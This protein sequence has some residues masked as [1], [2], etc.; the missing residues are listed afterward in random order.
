MADSWLK[1]CWLTHA[2]TC[3]RSIQAQQKPEKRRVLA[4]QR[5][6][7][8]S[9]EELKS[10]AC[11]EHSVI[12]LHSEKTLLAVTTMA[13]SSLDSHPG[14]LRLCM[15]VIKLVQGAGAPVQPVCN[16]IYEERLCLPCAGHIS[17]FQ[18]QV[19]YFLSHCMNAGWE[20]K[21][22]RLRQ[23]QEEGIKGTSMGQNSNTARAVDAILRAQITS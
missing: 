4:E 7:G 8:L 10:S 16:T 13:V 22:K 11:T 20:G 23:R 3:S 21:E 5:D 1:R 12:K 9:Y 14:D 6:P 18:V 19:V 17:S 2:A 15:S